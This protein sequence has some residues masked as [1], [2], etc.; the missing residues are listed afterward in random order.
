MSELSVS[1]L[2]E[3][4]D[5]NPNEGTFI[6][7]VARRGVRAG[8]TCGRI[9]VHGYRE[10]GVEGTL[11]RANRLAWFYV[12]GNWPQG[13]VDHVDG[14]KA[15]DRWSNLRDCSQSQNMGNMAAK[16][17]NNTT[18]HRGVVW[19]KA[20]GKWRAQICVGGA[21]RN[22]GRFSELDAAK[23]AYANAHKAAFGSFS[24]V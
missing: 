23:Q 4:M 24:N 22:L 14:D 8:A 6:W 1:R 11:Y 5:Y 9:S 17:I 3:I 12:T 13:V 18:G 16:R 21:K 7:R 19:D 15:N 20:R 10:I 2:R